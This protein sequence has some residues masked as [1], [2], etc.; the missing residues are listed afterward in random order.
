MAFNIG[1]KSSPGP[2]GAG[3]RRTDR[4]PR[5]TDPRVAADFEE[6]YQLLVKV[7]ANLLSNPRGVW[8]EVDAFLQ[9]QEKQG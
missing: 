1:G 6:M 4:I 7:R 8:E 5:G 3:R 2:D 9:R